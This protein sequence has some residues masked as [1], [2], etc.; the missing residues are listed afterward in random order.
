MSLS[1]RK[2]IQNNAAITLGLAAK[3]SG[4]NM[5]TSDENL[6]PIRIGVV[7]TGNRGR[8]LLGILL[9]IKGVEIPALCD[10]N[11]THL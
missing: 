4:F 9:N 7:G 11:K 5:L 1:R 8:G 10:I 3:A 2:F 6:K